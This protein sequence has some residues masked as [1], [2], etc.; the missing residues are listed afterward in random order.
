MCH[1]SMFVYDWLCN[2]VYMEMPQVRQL[3][4]ENVPVFAAAC[5][6]CGSMTAKVGVSV[7]ESAP[8]TP[9]RTSWA[10]AIH[11]DVDI[12]KM[13]RATVV[14]ATYACARRLVRGA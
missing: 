4:F 1:V 9:L 13:P 11:P 6:S 5:A 8:A 12:R 3:Q 14:N 7:P 2:E 10:I